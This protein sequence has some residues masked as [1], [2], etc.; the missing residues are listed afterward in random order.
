MAASIAAV[1]LGISI[2]RSPQPLAEPVATFE[3]DAATAHTVVL[4]DGS[5]VRLAPGSR[6][7]QWPAQGERRLSL[8]GRAFFAVTHDAVRPFTVDVADAQIRVL[9]TRFEVADV[10]GGVR[11]VVVEGRVGV[12]NAFGSAE[13]AAGSV[14]RVAAGAAP[15]VSPVEDVRAL[16]DWPEGLL[17]FQA[18]P[19]RD[20]AAEVGRHFGR[21]VEVEG[22]ELGELRISAFFEEEVFE[23]V[24]QAIEDFWFTVVKFPPVSAR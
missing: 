16:L 23:E 8:T 10:N 22:M 21:T 12:S 9:G 5:F 4:D 14:A 20:V 19:L 11:A 17:V 2:A 1:A 6:L 15:A 13:A 18:T 24:V 7:E 3:A